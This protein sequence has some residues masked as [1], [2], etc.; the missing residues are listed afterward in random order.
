ME[1]KPPVI[2]RQTARHVLWI[3]GYPQGL[4]PGNFSAKLLDAMAFAPSSQLDLLGRGYPEEVAAIRLAKYDENG[5]A[6]LQA[7]AAGEQVAA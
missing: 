3:F 1:N 5:I 4:Q 7:I 6:T 2:T